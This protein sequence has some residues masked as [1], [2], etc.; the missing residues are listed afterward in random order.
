MDEALE[1][2][3]EQELVCST[4]RPE[5]I[6]PPSQTLIRVNAGVQEGPHMAAAWT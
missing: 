4:P 6:A 3:L 5:R 2:S 1:A